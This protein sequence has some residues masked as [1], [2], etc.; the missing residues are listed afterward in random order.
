MQKT[1]FSGIQPTGVPHIGHYL[2]ALTNYVALSRTH[3]CVYSI[4]DMHAITVRQDPAVLRRR[5]LEVYAVILACE[6]ERPGTVLFVQSHV[7]A[8]AE[9]CWILNNFAMFGELS[10][11]TQFKDKSAKH[12]DNINAGLFT[13]PVLQ[14]ADILLYGA[15]IVPIGEDQKQHLEL[16]R[17]IAVRFNGIYGD[18]L[19][20][21]EPLIPKA[22]GRI[23]SLLDPSRKMDK[24]D[25]NPGAYLSMLDDKDT[26]IKKCKR[27]VTDSGAEVRYDPDGKPGVSNLM[28]IY[29]LS[30]GK[31]MPEVEREFAGKGY[32][33]F[34]QAVGEASD[35]LL[36]PI[37]AKAAEYIQN[38]AH[39][40]KLMAEEAERA[41]AIAEPVLRRVRDVIGFLPRK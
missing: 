33:A 27:A 2:G 38:P 24:S 26:I 9:L 34:K 23:M 31:E 19:T 32:G 20:V 5:T 40:E 10:R 41:E 18:V 30:S 6:P 37:R 7:P 11:M 35:R 16:S 39:L 3:R 29:G 1:V 12:A 17:D 21:P 13:Y 4:V 8:H 15:H 25:P 28:T 36:A 22:G 14:A